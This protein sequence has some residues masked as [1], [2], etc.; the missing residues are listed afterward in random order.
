[1]RVKTLHVHPGMLAR[2]TLTCKAKERLLGSSSSV[3][4]YTQ[5]V[6]TK[7]QL[8][9]VRVVRVRRG[10]TILVSATRRGLDPGI[11][12]EVQVQAVCAT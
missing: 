8:A 6:P 10:N 5:D 3:G 7:A 4:L 2:A 9:A 12:A 11:D 1:M